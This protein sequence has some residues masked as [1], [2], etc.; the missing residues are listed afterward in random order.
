MC[1]PATEL[2]VGYHEAP[3]GATKLR[4]ASEAVALQQGW[5]ASR[6]FRRCQ[7][8]PRSGRTPRKRLE[9]IPSRSSA[10]TIWPWQGGYPFGVNLDDKLDSILDRKG[11]KLEDR[12]DAK[13]D[14]KLER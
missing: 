2:S 1:E 12:I 9:R 5:T 8:N 14:A 7:E 6:S 3:R 10:A 4:G 13:L 11:K